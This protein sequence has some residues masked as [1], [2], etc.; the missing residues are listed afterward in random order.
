MKTINN[1][2]RVDMSAHTAFLSTLKQGLPSEEELVSLAA[3]MGEED[4]SG[5]AGLWTIHGNGE[6]SLKGSTIIYAGPNHTDLPTN[7][8]FKYVVGISLPNG[9]RTYLHYN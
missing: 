9:Q 2:F 1:F 5:G 4:K 7:P 6:F 3:I 8:L